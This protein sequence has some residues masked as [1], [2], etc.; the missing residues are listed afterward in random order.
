MC[1]IA[2]IFDP[3]APQSGAASI[4]AMMDIVR[5]RGP[6]DEG[7]ASFANADASVSIFSGIDTPKPGTDE[8][9]AY[10]PDQT[11]VDGNPGGSFLWLGHRRLAILDISPG[12]HQPMCSSDKDVWIV[13]NGEV[14]NYIELREELKLLG[15]SFNSESD[16]EVILAA[17]QQWGAD[18]LR[19]FNGMF[20][21][22]LFD[23]KRRKL[24]AA[25]DRFGVKPL[26][27]WASPD[28]CLAFASE[29]KQFTVLQG[30]S[31]RLNG[32]RAYDF[33]NW[34]ITD[35]TS[36]TL[37]EG[38]FQLKNGEAL[39]L[40]LGV[41]NSPPLVAP[42]RQAPAYSWYDLQPVNFSGDYADAVENVRSLLTDSIR[43][44]LRA[45][46]AVGSCLSGGLDSSSIVCIMNAL[47]REQNAH[48][49]QKT[50]SARAEVKEFDEKEFID[51]VTRTT[52]V[53]SYDVYPPFEELFDTL[54][55][56]TWHQD[57]PF[58]STSI[59]AQWHVF[60]LAAANEVKVILDG[61]GADEQLA[62]YHNYFGTWFAQLVR[63][64]RWIRLAREI[65]ATRRVHGYSVV[66]A[67]KQAA[68]NLIPDWL[69]QPLRHWV[70]KSSAR[71]NLINL[72][73]LKAR[74]LDPFVNA[75]ASSAKSVQEQSR[76]Q[77]VAT[78]LQMLLHW[79]DRDS[80]AHS[81]E[82][83]VP[84]LDFRLVEFILGLPD[85]YRINAGITKRV[86]RDAMRGVLPERVR[87]RMDKLGFVTPEESWLRERNPEEFR[88]ALDAAINASQRVIEPRARDLLNQMIAGTKPFSFQIWRLISFGA[89]MRVF[90]VQV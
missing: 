79:E 24:F 70:G 19:H 11:V 65:S 13:Y 55:T 87:M 36:E 50:F 28:G 81:I 9:L 27:Y 18:C 12:G 14:Y 21:F 15:R 35:H 3:H 51:E 84:F 86:L 2:A 62:G 52:A 43:L 39:E 74:P 72:G 59:Y 85:D 83:R 88:A 58:G 33:L 67:I 47:L 90:K 16:T 82:A 4:R 75:G 42:G 80:M 66:W 54:D 7:Y 63:E 26:Y 41:D 37:F 71:N 77:L 61:Q 49:L 44:R 46:V 40:T 25:R 29:I 23:R 60:K 48:S 78:T 57:E 68:N 34:G 30:W 32:Q 5:Y 8:P 22:V 17:Y 89:W 10:T 31:P 6:D 38:V 20:A 56:I 73:V 53:Q 64:A 76:I 45:D 1:G 69:R